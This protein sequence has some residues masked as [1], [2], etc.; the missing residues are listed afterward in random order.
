MHLGN[1]CAINNCVGLPPG[2]ACDVS[3][4]GAGDG[5]CIPFDG[6]SLI[7][8]LCVLDGTATTCVEATSNDDPLI[9]QPNGMN[10]GQIIISPQ[11]KS[12]VSLFC[13]AGRACYVPLAPAFGLDDGGGTCQ[14]LC[15]SP[16]DGGARSSCSSQDVCVV[17][18][19]DD[20]SWG[21]CLP[22]L[23]S[24]SDGGVS[25]ECVV[26]TDC[27]ESNC[28]VHPGNSYGSCQPAEG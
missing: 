10:G 9:A 11:P 23:S 15:P 20:R 17:Q 19:A 3:A 8:A 5:T 7:F 4:P 22:C 28:D 6:W 27:C 25:A 13:G 16:G 1:T 21:F 12:D 24:G 14:P 18:D 26:D 2:S